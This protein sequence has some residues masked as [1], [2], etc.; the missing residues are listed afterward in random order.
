MTAQLSA[1]SMGDAAAPPPQP[2]TPP[3]MVPAVEGYDVMGLSAGAMED[4]LRRHEPDL[5]A[6]A[7]ARLERELLG[8]AHSAPAPSAWQLVP[9]FWRLRSLAWTDAIGYDLWTASRKISR[10]C[11]ALPNGDYPALVEIMLADAAFCAARGAHAATANCFLSWHMAA[12]LL[13]LLEAQRAQ[14]EKDGAPVFVWNNL[15]CIRQVMAPGTTHDFNDIFEN[16]IRLFR[17]TLVVLA[18]WHAPTMLTRIWCLAEIYH[19]VRHGCRLD[20]ALSAAQRPAFERAL[21]EDF[22]SITMALS[23][24]D[25][26]KAEGRPEDVPKIMAMVEAGVGCQKLNEIVLAQ[27]RAWVADAGRA[28]LAALPAAERATSVLLNNVAMLLQ[29]QGRLDEARPLFEEYMAGCRAARGDTHPETLTAIS[30]L[31]LLLQGQ[32][33]LDEARPLL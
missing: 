12:P 22:D 6:A 23:K 27:M 31:G 15:F 18:P 7:R 4:F 33:R 17:R 9:H 29:E 25:V 1:V 26:R 5:V 16:T 3:L 21:V 10:R 28:A 2:T 30:N 13:S 20:V 32:G 19:T 8:L 14:E 11:A 24:I